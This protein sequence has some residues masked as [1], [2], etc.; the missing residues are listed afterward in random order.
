MTTNNPKK[1]LEPASGRVLVVRNKVPDTINGIHIPE[2][3]REQMERTN[4]RA[5]VVAVGKPYLTDSGDLV[6]FE[7]EEGDEVF[8]DR[9]AGMALD[10]PGTDMVL[11][12]VGFGEVIGRFPKEEESAII[13]PDEPRIIIP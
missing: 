2:I 4:T 1:L 3:E 10:I 11:N 13:T 5:Q 12:V 6:T 7:F 8:V 9:Y